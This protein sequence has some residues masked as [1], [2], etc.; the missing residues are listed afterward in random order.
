MLNLFVASTCF[1]TSA[2][3]WQLVGKA[4]L[5]RP[6]YQIIN[7]PTSPKVAMRALA[8]SEVYFFD[9]RGTLIEK[10][11]EPSGVDIGMS[12]NGTLLRSG[13]VDR[14]LPKLESPRN[15]MVR[16]LI[17]TMALGG[18]STTTTI[19]IVDNAA[20]IANWDGFGATFVSNHEWPQITAVDRYGRALHRKPFLASGAHPARVRRFAV[21]LPENQIAVLLS[22]GT[23]KPRDFTKVPRLGNGGSNPVRYHLMIIDPATGYARVIATLLEETSNSFVADRQHLA[24]MNSGRTLVVWH[25]QA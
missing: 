22:N 16:Y 20:A 23:M 24:T 11:T 13:T 9:A 6:G 4:T 5:P 12:A 17:P 3:D 1:L 25:Q 8:S 15:H 21:A 18:Q 7:H 2:A 10:V 19:E 14:N